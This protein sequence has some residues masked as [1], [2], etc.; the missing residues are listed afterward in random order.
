MARTAVSASTR[1]RILEASNILF[2]E[3]GVY[4][5]AVYRI[6]ASLGI[7]PGSLTYHF[8]VKS[9]IVSALARDLETELERSFT[10]SFTTCAVASDAAMMIDHLN[11]VFSLL[12]KFRFFFNTTPD[13]SGIDFLR[14]SR[15]RSFHAKI[16][17]MAVEYFEHTI[18]RQA[19]RTPDKPNSVILLA[20]NAVAVWTDWLRRSPVEDPRSLIPS[21]T[22]LR[23]GLAHHFSLIGPYLDTSFARDLIHTLYAPVQPA[24]Q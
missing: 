9:E 17:E 12:W 11:Q 18:A 7:S 24:E 4:G 6:A 23:D 15:H 21:P 8:K 13:F 16:C 10:H 20:D 22:A 2:N 19:M 5:T 1:E 14:T 3:H